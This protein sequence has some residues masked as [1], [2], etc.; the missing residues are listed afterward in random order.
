M[1]N[2]PETKFGDPLFLTNKL[3]I[4]NISYTKNVYDYQ[5]KDHFLNHETLRELQCNCPSHKHNKMPCTIVTGPI[6]LKCKTPTLEIINFQSFLFHPELATKNPLSCCS[7]VH[8]PPCRR[9]INCQTNMP[10]VITAPFECWISTGV[11]FFEQKNNNQMIF[12]LF[13]LFCI[14]TYIV[15][16]FSI[17]FFYCLDDDTLMVICGTNF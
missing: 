11:Y 6:C 7:H 10:C 14:S 2:N 4:V 16:I 15:Y 3:R 9:C 12:Y 1:A 13:R 8:E 5:L 17:L